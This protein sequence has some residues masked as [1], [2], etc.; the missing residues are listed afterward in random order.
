MNLCASVRSV[1]PRRKI[2]CEARWLYTADGLA[3]QVSVV[4]TRTL[5]VTGAIRVGQRPWGIAVVRRDGA[6]DGKTFVRNDLT[7]FPRGPI[8]V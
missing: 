2:P 6:G 5:R 7:H 1:N 3:N 8:L 4:H